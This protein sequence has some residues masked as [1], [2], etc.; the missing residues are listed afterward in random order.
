MIIF[1]SLLFK[2]LLEW[3]TG[4]TTAALQT[5]NRA[6]R[7]LEWGERALYNIIEICLNPDNELYLF[8]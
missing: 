6:R 5:F 1:S 2:G 3:Y 8:I 7:D 4:D